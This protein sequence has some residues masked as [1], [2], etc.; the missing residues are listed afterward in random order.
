MNYSICCLDW[1]GCYR[2]VSTGW[3]QI[4]NVKDA[5]ASVIDTP[6]PLVEDGDIV[7]GGIYNIGAYIFSLK[8]HKP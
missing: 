7:L 2:E 3:M 5:S 1:L 8:N 4:Q 6:L